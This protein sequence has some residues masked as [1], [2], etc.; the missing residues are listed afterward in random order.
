MSK[1]DS[2]PKKNGFPLPRLY[3]V[4]I[5]HNNSNAEGIFNCETDKVEIKSGSLTA[6]IPFQKAFIKQA[7][8]E[9]E[10]LISN[11]TLIEDTKNRHQ[12]IKAC[13]FS[14]GLSASIIAR[15]HLNGADSWRVKSDL[16]FGI[17]STMSLRFFQDYIIQSG[18]NV[19]PEERKKW[20]EM[21]ESDDIPYNNIGKY[22]PELMLE[23]QRCI[24]LEI[25]T[26]RK[27]KR[28]GRMNPDGQVP[29]LF[30]VIELNEK[31]H[32]KDNWLTYTDYHIEREEKIISMGYN[33]FNVSLRDWI[34]NKNLVI[35]NFKQY[36]K[37]TYGSV[38]LRDDDLVV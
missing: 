15:Q 34:N 21:Q 37:E 29:E 24:N 16:L 9:Y 22:E 18:K 11:G 25:L 13:T 30:L 36:I 1:H 6:S 28:I 8:D 20:Y 19:T 7:R 33:V 27:S 32:F 38:Y 26:R 10:Y 5:N 14:S 31:Q 3:P 23:L 35:E 17:G 2:F 12:F 4:F